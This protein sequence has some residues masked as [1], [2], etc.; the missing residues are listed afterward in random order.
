MAS[1]DQARP[2]W[3]LISGECCCDPNNGCKPP[4]S[5]HKA[6]Q[7]VG[8][9]IV[10]PGLFLMLTVISCITVEHD[11]SLVL[12]A[13]LLCAFG[14]WV[15]S[16]LYKS[17][18]LR[19]KHRAISWHFLTALTAGVTIWCTHFIAMLGYRPS[20]PV[21]FDYTLTILSL[22]IA[23]AGSALGV[24]FA[25]LSKMRLAPVFGGA[26]LGL[27]I[28]GMHYAGMIAYRVQGVVFWDKSFLAISIVLAVVF[29]A[30]ALCLGS[31]TKRWSEF[32]MTGALTVGIVSLHFTGMTAFHVEPMNI[33]GE[34]VNPEAF[35]MLAL[36]IAG[37]AVLIVVG[38]F[39]SYAVENRI[40][41]ESI[42]EL[43]EARNA[44]EEAS[45]AKSEF[46]S[47]LSHE[48]RT[49][50][51][52]VLGY[53]GILTKL[54]EHHEKVA[55][56]NGEPLDLRPNPIGEQAELYGQKITVAADHLLTLIN[57]IL[58]YTSMELDDA[59]LTKETFPL[60]ALL[61]QVADQFEKLALDKSIS[62]EVQSEQIEALADRGRILQILINLVGNAVKFS[63]GSK[64]A[65]SAQLSK[66]GFTIDVRDNG[67]GIPEEHLDR[68][69][70]AFQQV[71][72]A[73]NRSEGGTGLG[74]AI[75]KRLAIAHGGDIKVRSYLGAGTTF[76]LS[77]PASA[78]VTKDLPAA[79]TSQARPSFR[80]ANAG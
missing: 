18:Q 22:I 47:V 13:G 29:A 69:F 55:A 11:L 28:A 3:C 35:K 57:E 17:A 56:R 32:Q 63:N 31:K 27:A 67:C 23:I 73:D 72:T 80:L 77:L 6:L 16:R 24:L 75:C 25:S 44:A 33:S 71:E 49:P 2:T 41:L 30:L 62:L 51:T 50:L 26:I 8:A 40:R 53:A 79:A 15:T 5:E 54:K 38:G 48:L 74:L 14:S 43:T 70:Q 59:K 61:D 36:A 68:I 1:R 76:T 9:I 78:V 64:I 66:D 4:H 46:M 10:S 39:M 12:V 60:P 42:K 52:I 20:A 19:P 58:D 34:F 65:L 21:N 7:L 37:T 45:R